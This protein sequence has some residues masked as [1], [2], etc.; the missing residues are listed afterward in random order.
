[1]LLKALLDSISMN[2]FGKITGNDIIMIFQK[3]LKSTIG[4]DSLYI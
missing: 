3:N 1:L 2:I 4:Y